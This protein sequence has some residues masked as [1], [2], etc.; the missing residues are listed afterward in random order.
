MTEN[1]K[2]GEMPSPLHY[3]IFN[4]KAKNGR[5]EKICAKVRGMLE[6]AGRRYVL[7]ETERR[8]HATALAAELPDDAEE[9]IVI[10][11]DGTF[12]EVLNGLKAPEKMR[13]A[14]IAGGTGND[15]CAGAGISEDPERILSLVLKGA[16]KET[17]YI[18]FGE[19]RCL[20]VGGLGMDVDVLE[21]CA[22]GRL[23]GRIK[24]LCSLVVSV[25]TFRGYDMTLYVN[26]EER[27]RRALFTAVCNGD[28]I[29]GGIRI[30]PHADPEDGK[31]E[32]VMVPQMGFFRMVRAFLSLMRGRILSFP[33]TEHDYCDAVRI[34]T[35]IPR[36]VQMDG[37]LYG[38]YTDVKAEI[39]RGLKI[40]R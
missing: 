36:T 1:E 4:P 8:G 12:H 5:S 20:N 25:L 27:K 19:K 40:Y 10:G 3:I 39:R 6:E 37:E 31:L 23:H 38:G 16:A 22:R 2:R 32:V 30:C 28:R 13:I 29:G 15:F 35:E 21:R 26:G 17:D 24:Y 14:F 18:A 11:G 7:L 9:L 34:T 33:E